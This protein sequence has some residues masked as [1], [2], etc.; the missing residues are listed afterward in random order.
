MSGRRCG[1]Q[2]GAGIALTA[3]QALIRSLVMASRRAGGVRGGV[4]RA[5]SGISLSAAILA[6]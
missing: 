6:L 5:L 1:G 4:P 2:V 3:C